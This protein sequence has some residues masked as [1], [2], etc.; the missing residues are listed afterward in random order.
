M[1][2]LAL[3]L[4]AVTALIM[5]VHVELDAWSRGPCRQF[6]VPSN[7]FAVRSKPLDDAP[8]RRE[9][10]GSEQRR[11]QDVVRQSRFRAA[12]GGFAADGVLH[13]ISMMDL[14]R[15]PLPALAYLGLACGALTR[16]CRR[17][18]AGLIVNSGP[19]Q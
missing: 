1:Q 10:S 4:L 13:E 11:V 7:R 2:L 17:A 6:R 19:D 18:G 9:P 15:G 5:S 3:R 12:S 16:I 14:A 8:K